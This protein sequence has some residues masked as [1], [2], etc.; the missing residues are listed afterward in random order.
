MLKKISAYNY[1]SWKEL[2]DL[3]LGKVTLLFG[4]NSSG[5]TSIIQ[6]L[7][8]LK[9]T[10]DSF[11]RAQP[12]NLGTRESLVE[13]GLY[14]DMIYAHDKLLPLKLELA[15]ETLPKENYPKDTAQ[16]ELEFN[17]ISDSIRVKRTKLCLGQICA[18]LRRTG[19]KGA[20]QLFRNGESV[21]ELGQTKDLAPI[22]CYGFPSPATQM[23]PELSDLSLAVEDFASRIYYLGPLR[24][25]PQREYLWSGSAPE[26]VGRSGETAI[27][28]ILAN[29]VE[30]AASKKAVKEKISDL[31]LSAET[32]LKKMQLATSF[33]V[34]QIRGTRQYKAV[35]TVPDLNYEANVAD[36][37][38]GVSQ[39]LPVVILAHFAPPGSIII[40]EQPE[41]HLH[42]SVQAI[43]AELFFEVS[44]QRNIQFIVETH[45]EYLLTRLQRRLAERQS[46][47]LTEKDVKLYVCKKA[48]KQ[49][50][51]DSLKLD[52]N[53][54]IMN[55]P[56][57]F[58][59]D[60]VSDREAIMR[61][62][63]RKRKERQGDKQAND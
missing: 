8:L 3:T 2:K 19:Q 24:V 21:V 6:L 28:A 13:L 31:V 46:G 45:S 39:V 40:L 16:I 22:K 47:E 23:Y 15:W 48:E 17:Y 30:R 38:I 53:G 55:W 59:G 42:P 58:F 27:Q 18:E 26:G 14:E 33:E 29:I 11:D 54:R 7:L 20:Y 44:A 63:I 35:L 51:I 12:L 34:Q 4:E 61:A 1:K 56:P 52:E 43:L 57:H 62:Y 5:K 25:R 37:G 10:V 41:L 50:V 60:T 49:S 32:W 36:V 9:Q